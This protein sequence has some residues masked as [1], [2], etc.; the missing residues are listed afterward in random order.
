MPQIR[1]PLVSVLLIRDGAEQL[2]GSGCCGVLTDDDPTVRH[3][4]VFRE[5]RRD[6]EH[7]GILH[8][9]V[10]RFF[11]KQIDNGELE[12]VIVDPR[13]QLYLAS[14]L[15]VDVFRFRPGFRAAVTALLQLFSVPAVVVN[16]RVI[17]K[18]GRATTPDELCHAIREHL[19]R[20]S[21]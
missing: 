3:R 7:F 4:N 21:S 14:R 19:R 2:T 20:E 17:S 5:T 8:R 13:N 11:A 1:R 9:S 15:M 12:V 6:Q 16:G 18:R 10:T